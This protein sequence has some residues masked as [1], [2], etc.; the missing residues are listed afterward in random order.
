MVA[1]VGQGNFTYEADKSWGRRAGGVPAFGVAQGVA[2]DSDDRVYV[3]N[4]SPM[5]CVMVFSRKGKLVD[6]WGAGLFKHPHGIWINDRD[7]MFLTDRDTQLVTKWTTEG[8][9]LR[10][11]GTPNEPG[12]PGAPFNQPTQAVETDDG[13]LYVSDGYGQ[14]R[15][16]RFA[17]NGDL[18]ASWGEQGDGPGQFGLPHNVMI[19]SRDRVLVSD[20]SNQRV[21]LFNRDG[22]YIGEWREL[23]L[24]MQIAEREKLLYMV[25]GGQRVSVRTLDNQVLSAWGSKG[26]GADQFRYSPH[27]I[28]VDSRGDIYVG[29]V[30]QENGFTK[31]HRA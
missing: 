3:F 25:E 21:Q 23:N 26:E 6:V 24:P 13:E 29:E 20:R 7:E 30:T 10:A 19:D 12:A 8:R 4:R 11:W 9:F 15:T 28:A 14:F 1:I 18:I 31:F 5:A 22:G 2:C 17:A 27:A 16:H